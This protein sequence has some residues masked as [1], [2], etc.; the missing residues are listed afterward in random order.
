[1]TQRWMS[2]AMQRRADAKKIHRH[3]SWRLVAINIGP[4]IGTFAKRKAKEREQMQHAHLVPLSRAN[5]VSHVFVDADTD[6]HI[7]VDNLLKEKNE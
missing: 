4:R 3:G 5:Q 7:G 2:V 6:A 1:M